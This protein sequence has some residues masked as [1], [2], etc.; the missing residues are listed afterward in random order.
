MPRRSLADQ[1]D[2]ALT[3]MLAGTGGQQEPSLAPLLRIAEELRHLPRDGFKA[4]L[5]SDLERK[6]SMASQATAAVVQTATTRLWLK[7][8]PAAIEFYEKAFGAKEISRFEAHGT[9]VVAEV[10]IGNSI[11]MLSESSPDLG[12]PGPETY[13]GSS[14][15]INL[16]VDDVDRF[17]ERA[18]AAGARLTQPVADQF[19]GDRRGS[20]SDPFGYAW[21]IATRKEELSVEEIYRRFETLERDRH[22]RTA[23]INPVPRGYHTITPYI[24]VPDAPALID[25]AQQVFAAEEVFRAI[26]GAG[27][28]HAEVRIGDSMLMIGGGGPD[29]AWH[30]E[31]KL[32]ALHIYVEDTDAAY[33]RALSAGAVSLHAPE[34]QPYGE[35]GGSVKDRFGNFW[36]LATWK[37]ASHVPTGLR[38]VTPY[39]HPLRAEPII[40]FLKRGFGAQEVAKHASPDGVIHHAQIR[41]GDS[42][43]EMGEAN[44]PYQP[45]QS[46]FYLYV[47]DVDAMYTRALT[48]GATSVSSP[49]DQPYGDRTAAVRDTFGNQWYI[50]T[51]IKDLS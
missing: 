23:V 6:T 42:M 48:A 19:Y 38:T 37:G 51:H 21:A 13:G 33:E 50:A 30:G 16:R 35:R 47:P 41:V 2:R 34:D 24:V 12:F 36:Y 15:T 20:V 26:G 17:V 11:I 4:R 39:L 43:L 28:I 40:G 3:E 31:S 45:M 22:S 27:G 5:K 32:M 46:M 49:A 7:N 29:L 9:I 25:F 1:L 44:G 18:V 10:R 14:I 8:A